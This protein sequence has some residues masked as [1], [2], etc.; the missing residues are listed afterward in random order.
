MIPGIDGVK[1][2]I[3]GNN[4]AIGDTITARY[5]SRKILLHREMC[6]AFSFVDVLSLSTANVK[7]METQF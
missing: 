4:T 1:A 3:P 7:A 5:D 2:I 6:V